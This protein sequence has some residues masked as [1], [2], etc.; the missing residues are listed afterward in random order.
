MKARPAR[1]AARQSVADLPAAEFAL[2]SS[3]S[4]RRL[5]KYA[6]KRSTKLRLSQQIQLLC[7]A[8]SLTFQLF[9]M[10]TVNFGMTAGHNFRKKACNRV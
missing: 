10:P 3:S 9:R 7:V 5:D 1:R 4:I 8:L 2:F 6:K